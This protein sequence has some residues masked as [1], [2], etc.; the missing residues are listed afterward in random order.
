MKLQTDK[1]G[2]LYVLL[3]IDGKQKMFRVGRLVATLF[4]PNPDGKPEVNHINGI[5]TDNRVENLEWVTRSENEQHAYD[6]GLAPLGED[7]P[8]AKLTAN[9]VLYIRDN[10]DRLSQ[11]ELAAKFNVTQ[12]AIGQIQRGETWRHVGGTIR[13]ANK[14]SPR[15]SDAQRLEIYQ[16][17]KA[18]GVSQRQLAAE[19][20]THQ[21]VVYHIIKE[22]E[23]Q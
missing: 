9:D 13:K 20:D 6:T 22:V 16:R 23:R 1:D 11:Y 4:I 3:S 7:A 18:G 5:K 12:P 21:S 10:P 2:Y 19:Y 17:Y 15:M 8:A 14:K